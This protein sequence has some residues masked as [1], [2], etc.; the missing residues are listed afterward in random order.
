MYLLCTHTLRLELPCHRRA[1]LKHAS[2]QRN[3]S[4]R[5][6]RRDVRHVR[7]R[8]CRTSECVLKVMSSAQCF[9]GNLG[10]AKQKSVV[11]HFTIQMA[12]DSSSVTYSHDSELAHCTD[13]RHV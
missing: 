6:P 7:L 5:I 12:G 11:Y 8:Y 4:I 9:C 2:V 1:S 10:N 13:L 3:D